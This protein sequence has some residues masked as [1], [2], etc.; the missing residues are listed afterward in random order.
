MNKPA[1]HG[2]CITAEDFG[3]TAYDHVGIWQHLDI[4]KVADGIVYDDKEVVFIG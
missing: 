3:K 2:V 1:T 4:D